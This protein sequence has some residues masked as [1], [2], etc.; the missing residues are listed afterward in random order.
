MFPLYDKKDKRDFIILKGIVFLG[1]ALAMLAAAHFG[2]IDL[3]SIEEKFSFG[4]GAVLLIMI[5]VL[6]IMNRLKALFKVKSVG[7]VVIFLTLLCLSVAMDVLLWGF[8]LVSIPLLFDDLFV[9]TYFKYLDIKKYGTQ[10][11]I[12]K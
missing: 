11:V 6:A 4:I 9:S 5:F 8:G 10:I 7:F 12:T 2:N 1:L 3:P